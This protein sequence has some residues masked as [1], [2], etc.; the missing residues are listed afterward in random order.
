MANA[1]VRPWRNDPYQLAWRKAMF[2][3]TPR[4]P[5][6]TWC[7]FNEKLIPGPGD[8]W[9]WRAGHF[10]KT[11]YAMFSI[12]GQDGKWR[13]TVAHRVAYE[14][15]IGEIPAGLDLDHL[16][17]NRGCVNPWHLEPVTRAVNLSRGMSPAAVAVRENRCAAGH[18]YTPENTYR[19]P[20]QPNKRICR[21][22]MRRRDNARNADGGRRE[23]Y[24]KMYQQRKA[25]RVTAS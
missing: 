19:K 8:C 14:L 16:C 4:Q 23:H 7:R 9:Y 24:R 25:R 3:G 11:G 10:K 2:K 6:S 12:R 18:E 15:Y 5:R 17:Q 20:S 22:C 21:E 1:T 13:P